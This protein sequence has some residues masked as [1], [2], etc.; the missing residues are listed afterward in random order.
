MVQFATIRNGDK[1]K[2]IFL[3]SWVLACLSWGVF[4]VVKA[5]TKGPALTDAD[6][7][8]VRKF[9]LDDA[10]I[11]NAIQQQWLAIYQ[12]PEYQRILSLQKQQ[13]QNAQNYTTFVAG[14][15]KQD[16]WQFS[17]DNDELKCVEKQKPASAPEKK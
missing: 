14:L 16:G 1:M 5:E 11:S 8:S 17:Q 6:K 12:T 4:L 7:T 13:Q 2:K 3:V 10:R 9:Q 15:C